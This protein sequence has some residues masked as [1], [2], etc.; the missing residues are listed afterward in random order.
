MQTQVE[1]KETI[2]EATITNVEQSTTQ[3]TA[4]IKKEVQEENKTLFNF[5]LK[6]LIEGG[7]TMVGSVREESVENFWNSL[8]GKRK[9]LYKAS[10]ERKLNLKSKNA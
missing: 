4:V 6:Q 7:F 3:K 5:R 8:I 2:Q 1:L 9:V 10:F